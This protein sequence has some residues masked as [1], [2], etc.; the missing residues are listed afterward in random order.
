[1]RTDRLMAL[2]C[3]H[4]WNTYLLLLSESIYQM[5]SIAYK[6]SENFLADCTLHLRKAQT[7]RSFRAPTENNSKD[8][9]IL[10]G[11]ATC[12]Y[13]GT[14]FNQEDTCAK[15]ASHCPSLQEVTLAESS[16]TCRVFCTLTAD[17]PWKQKHSL[18]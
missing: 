16:N 18:D 14:Q 7:K 4:W 8:N 3:R 1:M 9:R 10:R 5:H 13:T 15:S 6:Y 17:N 2:S 12:L 11:F